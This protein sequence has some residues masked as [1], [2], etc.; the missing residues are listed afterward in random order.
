MEFRPRNGQIK[1]PLKLKSICNGNLRRLNAGARAVVLMKLDPAGEHSFSDAS[2]R[3]IARER[4]CQTI[5]TVFASRRAISASA[6]SNQTRRDAAME[7]RALVKTPMRSGFAP[8]STSPAEAT[9]MSVSLPGFP[10]KTP[11]EIT[12]CTFLTKKRE[13]KTEKRRTSRVHR[14]KV[15]AR[16]ERLFFES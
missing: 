6:S 14:R 12:N 7:K 5:F 16:R 8:I 9:V 2:H 3:K 15:P 13:G 4:A 11:R 10:R 1:S